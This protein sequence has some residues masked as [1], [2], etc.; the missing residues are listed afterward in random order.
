V[1]IYTKELLHFLLVSVAFCYSQSSIVFNIGACK[2]DSFAKLARSCGIGII[3]ALGTH[4]TIYDGWC[5]C[6]EFNYANQVSAK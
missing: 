2:S 3:S 6:R 4:T 1:G 5:I